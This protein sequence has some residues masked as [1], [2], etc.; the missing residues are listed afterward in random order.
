MT[1][2]EKPNA[3]NDKI[4]KACA[5]IGYC[6]PYAFF[7]LNSGKKDTN[8]RLANKLGIS[9]SAIEFNKRRLKDKVL[10][11]QSRDSCQMRHETD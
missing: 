8:K 10:V 7:M 3:R 2:E 1:T 9:E 4:N 6:C 11:C 5:A